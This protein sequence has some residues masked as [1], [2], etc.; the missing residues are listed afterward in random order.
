LATVTIARRDR[1][2]LSLRYGKHAG[3]SALRFVPCAPGTQRDSERSR[4]VG[5][6]TAWAGGFEVLR[7]GCATLQVRR[8]GDARPRS[9]RVG[10]GQ[11]CPE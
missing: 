2:W 1:S 6:E 10:F 7:P 9:L 11:A 3:A 5:P 8:A 4:S